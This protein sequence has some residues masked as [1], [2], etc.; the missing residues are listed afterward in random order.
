MS[1]TIYIGKISTDEKELFELCPEA[2]YDVCPLQDQP[3][4]S[5]RSIGRCDHNA[6]YAYEMIIEIFG[7]MDTEGPQPLTKYIDTI[8]A[9]RPSKRDKFTKDRI[10]FLKYWSE[11]ALELYGN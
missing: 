3:R 8:R 6:R 10:K 2:D 4:L 1:L 7:R 5:I 9:Y 11:K